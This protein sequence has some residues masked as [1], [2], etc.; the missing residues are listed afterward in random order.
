MI[1]GLFILSSLTERLLKEQ[2]E[3][4]YDFVFFSSLDLLEEALQKRQVGAALWQRDRFL[5]VR[6][7]QEFRDFHLPVS[8]LMVRSFLEKTLLQVPYLLGPYRFDPHQRSLKRKGP[9]GIQNIVL[10]EKESEI[11]LYL[12]RAPQMCASRQ[13]LLAAIWGIQPGIET[14]TLETHIYQ[15]R[16]KI[17][18]D[19][20]QMGEEKDLILNTDEGYCLSEKTETLSLMPLGKT[21]TGTDF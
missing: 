13:D 9:K 19:L 16:H 21:V 14:R 15:L 18:N 11:L 7:A 17:K 8:L 3:L 5:H 2:L 1:L 6:S 20:L 12:L 10:R 4:H